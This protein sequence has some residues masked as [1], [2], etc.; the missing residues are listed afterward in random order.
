[1]TVPSLDK[2]HRIESEGTQ[3]Y[4]ARRSW[5]LPGLLAPCTVYFNV[6][7]YMVVEGPVSVSVPPSTTNSS[8]SPY[9]TNGQFVTPGS[10]RVVSPERGEERAVL[11]SSHSA[12]REQEAIVGFMH[13][14]V[15]SVKH[16]IRSTNDH[17]DNRCN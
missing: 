3:D 10:S 11:R 12:L 17:H 1:M 5:L 7:T 13:E 15:S 9:S 2:Q 16:A 8:I 14:T 4:H 6:S